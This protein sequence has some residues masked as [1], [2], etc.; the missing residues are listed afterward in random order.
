MENKNCRPT[1]LSEAIVKWI[2]RKTKENKVP[3]LSSFLVGM[4]C[5]IFA[6]TNKLVNHDEVA[7]LFAKGA[8][9]DSGRW[10]LGA[11]DSIFPN[12]S[13]PWIYGVITIVLITAAICILIHIF[14]IQ[15]KLLQGLL[16]G[17]IIAF[18][19]LIGTFGYMFTSS[20][21]AVS[22]LLAVL[23]VWF[24][25]KPVKYYGI[26]ALMC[27]VL[28]LS[29]YQSYIAVTASLLVLVLIRQL[30]SGEDAVTVLKKG[31]F[32]VAFLIIS[33]GLYYVAT[34]LVFLLTGT[35]F[36]SYASDSITFSLSSVFTGIPLAYGSFFRFLTE[37]YHGLIPTVF[38]RW[39]HC[40]LLASAGILLLF[41]ALAQKN[42]SI[43]R[44][45]LLAA[46]I[47]ILP[48]AVNC[49]YLI[50]A[51]DSIHTLVLYGFT[52]VYILAILIAD[53]CLPLFSGSKAGELCRRIALEAAAV[54]M[55]AIIVSNVYI[56]NESYLNLYLRYENAYAFYTSLIADIKMMPEFDE[57]TRLAVI[58]EWD[59][60]DYFNEHFEFANQVTGVKGFFPDSYS[61]NYFL[62]YYL[63]FS[64]PFASEEEIEAV[65]Q[66]PQ[67]A[68]MAVYPYYGSLQM[69]GDIL[70]V[71]LS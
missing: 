57:G 50:T 16:A 43:T 28:S 8:T 52:A 68:E 59:Y 20:S 55:A 71:K 58:G 12:Y 67:Y 70:V 46:L 18:P 23:A 30:L 39:M 25:R 10:G 2:L 13:M 17:S 48:L 4:L 65:T 38:S 22:F 15:N 53:V 45:L 19:S 29:I 63:G 21:Y 41:W 9:V 37:G 69:I 11:L 33:L 27:M 44:F 5:Y 47:G 60:P 56:A 66:T 42:R 64:V 31:V 32:Y 51:A 14:R 62:E 36:N 26:P 49:M 40:L 7:S 35:Q 6:F 61:A 54:A 24:I 1:L 3:I 34:Q